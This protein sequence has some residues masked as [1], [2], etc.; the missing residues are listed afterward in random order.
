MIFKVPSVGQERYKWV[1]LYPTCIL[2]TWFEPL[3]PIWSPST[4]TVSTEQSQEW[5][6]K[7]EMW[8]SNR[9]KIQSSTNLGIFLEVASKASLQ[10]P[11]VCSQ[12]S[13]SSPGR[14][15]CGHQLMSWLP[16]SQ[17][18]L[19]PLLNLFHDLVCRQRFSEIRPITSVTLTLYKKS[20]GHPT[21]LT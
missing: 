20:K 14:R 16:L 19:L 6:L 4:T 5:S 9:K 1:S 3:H 17:K 2:L 12:G 11:Q 15:V 13:T 8:L 7:T 10:L 21:T 18:A